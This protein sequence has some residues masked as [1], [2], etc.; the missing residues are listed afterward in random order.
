MGVF[1]LT[2]DFLNSRPADRTGRRL[3]L[4]GYFRTYGR[5]LT[6]PYQ[7]YAVMMTRRYRIRLRSAQANTN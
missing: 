7:C 6:E 5:A 4:H 1:M 2:L 3:S